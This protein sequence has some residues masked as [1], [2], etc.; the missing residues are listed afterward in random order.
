[1]FSV[2]NFYNVLASNLLNP[3]KMHYSY[4]YPF[5]TF[6]LQAI[7]LNSHTNYIDGSMGVLFWDQEPFNVNLFN[8]V[9]CNSTEIFH[10]QKLNYSK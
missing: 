3:L 1:M 4:F 9:I 10:P 2:D 6:N 7:S 8:E 5:G